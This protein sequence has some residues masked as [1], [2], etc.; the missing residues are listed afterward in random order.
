MTKE[1]KK[2]TVVRHRPYQAPEGWLVFNAPRPIY[3][4]KDWIGD[5]LTGVFFVA[6]DPEGDNAE[7]MIKR[8]TELDARLLEYMSQEEWDRQVDEYGAM[9]AE[10]HGINLEDHSRADIEQSYGNWLNRKGQAIVMPA[11]RPW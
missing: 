9:M 7:W 3:G 2:L 6:V 4:H 11:R 10:E 1:P 8:N 5:F